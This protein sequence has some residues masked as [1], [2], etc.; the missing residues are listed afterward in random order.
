VDTLLGSPSCMI[1]PFQFL[2]SLQLFIKF[3]LTC[4]TLSPENLIVSNFLQSKVTTWRTRDIETE[5]PPVQ[6]P[7]R[8][9]SFL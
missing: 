1:S 4:M 7:F 2:T 5:A 6:L 3:G 8:Y 9:F